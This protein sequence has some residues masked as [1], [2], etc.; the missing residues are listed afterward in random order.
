MKTKKRLG[1]MLVEEGLIDSVRLNSALAYQRDWGGR[2]GA[3]LIKKGY[4]SEREMVDVI[5]RQLR[6]KSIS[7]ENIDIPRSEIL[8]LVKIDIAKKYCICPIDVDGK[9]LLLAVTDPTD[10][11]TIDDL[12]F[13]IGVRIKPLLALETDILR[14]IE[15]FYE[16]GSEDEP[17]IKMDSL[18]STESG[19][20]D[21]SDM[22]VVDQ[23]IYSAEDSGRHSHP[24]EREVVKPSTDGDQ[25]LL[26]E[27]IVDLLV[28]KGI[29]TREELRKKLKSK[30]NG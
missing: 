30:K 21:I 19:Y 13:L 18:N 9:N 7:L 29:I 15:R 16:G 2:L 5:E 1:E 20:G 4:V 14:A 3:I 28:D 11:K 26:L 23:H 24:P 12:S 27:G 17:V 22:L 6:I 8:R 10:L 25:K